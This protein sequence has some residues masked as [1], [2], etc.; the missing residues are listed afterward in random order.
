MKRIYVALVLLTMAGLA[1]GTVLTYSDDF[2][3][4]VRN[5]SMWITD[6]SRDGFMAETGGHLYGYAGTNKPSYYN[7]FARWNMQPI[8]WVVPNDILE[9]EALF[10]FPEGAVPTNRLVELEIGW[11]IVGV[12]SNLSARAKVFN[13]STNRVLS[14]SLYNET[15]SPVSYAILVPDGAAKL[16][17]KLRYNSKKNTVGLWWRKPAVETWTLVHTMSIATIWGLTPADMPFLRPYVR[18]RT[19]NKGFFFLDPVYL[20]NFTARLIVP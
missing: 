4:G 13:F 18:I 14:L 20:D 8:Q 19:Q 10:R 7:R 15:A 11:S 1:R 3:D 2:N 12:H 6:Y 17:L 9:V 16:Y 5:R